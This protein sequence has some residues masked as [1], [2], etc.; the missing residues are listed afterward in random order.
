MLQ[1]GLEDGDLI[2][3]YLEMVGGGPTKKSSQGDDRSAGYIAPSIEETSS[4]IIPNAQEV[5]EER[6]P[7][8]YVDMEP[9]ITKSNNETATDDVILFL[10]PASRS[11]LLGTPATTGGKQPQIKRG[12]TIKV[13]DD[14]ESELFLNVMPHTRFS[15]I[16]KACEKH[17]DKTNLRFF[18]P[19]GPRIL[20]EDT[21]DTVSFPLLSF[22]STFMLMNCLLA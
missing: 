19:D 3:A 1:I 10:P 21:P 13:K 4:T 14:T 11:E 2:D 12:M 15:V 6:L 20:S 17:W 5:A 7:E 16:M 8:P 9:N 22:Q 18:S